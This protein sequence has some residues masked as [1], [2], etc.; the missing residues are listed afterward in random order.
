MNK[1]EEIRN[2]LILERRHCTYLIQQCQ[3]W[4]DNDD[5]HDAFEF[6]GSLIND[7]ISSAYKRAQEI[8]TQIET[9]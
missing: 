5:L 4:I 7:I 3:Q 2:T 8:N 6:E 1:L 9:L